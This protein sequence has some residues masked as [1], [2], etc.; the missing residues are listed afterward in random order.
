MPRDE[1]SHLV[2]CWSDLQLTAMEESRLDCLV[3]DLRSNWGLAVFVHRANGMTTLL[4][5]GPSS[6]LDLLVHDVRVAGHT[7]REEVTAI[8]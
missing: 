4:A 8:A 5:S 7:V 1:G 3:E 6:K 2:L